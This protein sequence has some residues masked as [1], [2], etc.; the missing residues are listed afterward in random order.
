[1]I[2]QILAI[3]F[4]YSYDEKRDSDQDE[5]LLHLY[6]YKQWSNIDYGIYDYL[7]TRR[8][9]RYLYLKSI[10]QTKYP[11]TNWKNLVRRVEEITTKIP[12]HEFLST[13]MYKE[14]EYKWDNE[15]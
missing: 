2:E 4:N 6:C 11:N 8:A 7:D 10:F 9:F 13:E 12:P 3:L 5:W 1:M 14:L 15:L